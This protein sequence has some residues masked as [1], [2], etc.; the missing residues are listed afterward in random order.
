MLIG[1]SGSAPEL[2]TRTCPRVHKPRI[3]T[4]QCG[5][6]TGPIW[7]AF[8]FS[9]RFSPTENRMMDPMS[10]T[11]Q[12]QNLHNH[13]RFWL[14][15]SSNNGR[16]NVF[17]IPSK[18]LLLALLFL[19]WYLIYRPGPVRSLTS[20]ILLSLSGFTNVHK[21]VVVSRIYSTSINLNRSIQ[22]RWILGQFGFYWGE[23]AV[24]SDSVFVRQNSGRMLTLLV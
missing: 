9:V 22:I 4:D 2:P 18:A 13:Y 6:W 24:R 21:L 19:C 8:R 7:C 5:L 12:P 3:G 14:K 11:N 23:L 16:T 1:R 15:Y 10:H 20:L 17:P